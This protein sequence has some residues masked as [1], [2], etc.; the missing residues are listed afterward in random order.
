MTNISV[1]QQA[2]L[3]RL[4]FANQAD[5][6]EEPRWR[7]AEWPQLPGG[8]RLEYASVVVD[9]PDN[10]GQRVVLLGGQSQ[11]SMLYL[12]LNSVFLLNVHDVH[13][14]WRE[15]RAMNKARSEFA[16]VVCHGALYAIGGANDESTLSTIER[17][18]IEDLVSSSVASDRDNQQWKT[19]DCRLSC[20]RK[21][22]AAVVVH[23]RFIIVAGGVGED[24]DFLSSIDIIDTCSKVNVLSYLDH[25]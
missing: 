9:H 24:D 15:G 11:S 25:I 5:I 18:N 7:P 2:Q 8:G 19:L 13:K 16:A 12:A 1:R 6:Q 14:E 3:S 17:I 20:D 21:G 22:C 4:A 23:D 10:K